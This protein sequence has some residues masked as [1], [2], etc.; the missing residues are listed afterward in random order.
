[1]N[2]SKI[3]HLIE[4]HAWKNRE[5]L[6]GPNGLL[7]F[8]NPGIPSLWNESGRRQDPVASISNSTY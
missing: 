7:L 4:R 6:F 5:E 2:S 8:G 1:M 3:V